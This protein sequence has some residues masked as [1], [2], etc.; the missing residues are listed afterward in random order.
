MGHTPTQLECICHLVILL[1]ERSMAA[2]ARVT[3]QC[4]PGH[5]VSNVEKAVEAMQL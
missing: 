2:D 1:L 5:V 4:A 3:K